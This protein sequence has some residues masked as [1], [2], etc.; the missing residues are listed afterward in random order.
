[1]SLIP[2]ESGSLSGDEIQG[3][4]GSREN[5]AGSLPEL[6]KTLA[7]TRRDLTEAEAELSA[8]TAAFEEENSELRSMIRYLKSSEGEIAGAVRALA[9]SAF[10]RSGER[11]PSEGVSIKV[12][13]TLTYDDG[14]AV[15]YCIENRLPHLLKVGDRKKLNGII[16]GLRLGFAVDERIPTA[17]IDSD[18][19]PLL[20][21]VE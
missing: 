2:A 8:K 6:L 14:D 13:S 16:R 12:L 3:S 9:V 5:G 15:A 1:M 11:R 7:R 4:G 21:A 10:Q 17:Y 19:S 18:L 20:G